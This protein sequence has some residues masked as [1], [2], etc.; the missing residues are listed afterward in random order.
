MARGNEAIL[1]E[2]I[3]ELS[4]YEQGALI[5]DPDKVIISITLPEVVT[6]RLGLGTVEAYI[7]RRSAKHILEKQ[8]GTFLLKNTEAIIRRCADIY[9]SH[10]GGKSHPYKAGLRYILAD[11]SGESTFGV[12]IQVN[13]IVKIVTTMT[14]N[15][16]YTKNKYKK[17][18]TN[19]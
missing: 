12:V 8:K 6:L 3:E 4:A 18:E 17:L 2:L 16:K 10:H 14:L 1:E 13:G 9:I 15:M 19:D 7:S 11:T 5:P